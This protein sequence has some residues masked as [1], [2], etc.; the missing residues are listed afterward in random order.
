MQDYL[1]QLIQMTAKKPL[2]FNSNIVTNSNIIPRPGQQMQIVERRLGY[3]EDMDF[4]VTL[5]QDHYFVDATSDDQSAVG[6]I[7]H[8]VSVKGFQSPFDYYGKSTQHINL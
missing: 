5:L 8:E 4:L 1:D 7:Y 2:S 3:S 6:S